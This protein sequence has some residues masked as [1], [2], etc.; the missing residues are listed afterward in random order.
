MCIH[1]IK[2]VLLLCTD[3][4][5]V[6]VVAARIISR[7]V[8]FA[9]TGFIASKALLVGRVSVTA[10]R[11][12]SQICSLP[13]VED[14]LQQA[15]ARQGQCHA[16]LHRC[17]LPRAHAYAGL[18]AARRAPGLGL[19]SATDRSDC[20]ALLPR[21]VLCMQMRVPFPLVLVVCLLLGAAV[22]G[23][24]AAAVCSGD[25]C[26]GE[27]NKLAADGV[28]YCCPTS[29]ALPSASDYGNPSTYSCATTQDC[30]KSNRLAHSLSA[31]L[32]VSRV[33]DRTSDVS[34]S[35]CFCITV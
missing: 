22:P 20:C 7:G 19:P 5:G 3:S 16:M 30:S 14:G 35:V 17:T 29:H 11:P 25:V 18:T 23:V 24:T 15:C 21:T 33:S 28:N 27:A 8:G 10:T 34:V 2:S 1:L 32:S 26:S 13:A 6:R 9:V 12:R 4:E 31:R